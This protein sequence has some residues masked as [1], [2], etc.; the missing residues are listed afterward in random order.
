MLLKT[1]LSLI[2]TMMLVF[3]KELFSSSARVITPNYLLSV[4]YLVINR[5][6]C[7]L[8]IKGLCIVKRLNRASA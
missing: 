3:K 8:N 5:Y 2:Y 4:A 7:P 6:F 1:L